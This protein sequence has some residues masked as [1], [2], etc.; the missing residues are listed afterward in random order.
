MAVRI[1]L[2]TLGRRPVF[3]NRLPDIFFF[4]TRSGGRF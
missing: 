3:I 1:G 2:T 4:F